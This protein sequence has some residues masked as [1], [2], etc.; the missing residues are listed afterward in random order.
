MK[1]QL[2]LW[3]VDFEYRFFDGKHNLRKSES[4]LIGTRS[5]EAEAAAQLVR[6]SFSVSGQE[7]VITAVAHQGEVFVFPTIA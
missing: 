4:A 6:N 5:E 2:S 7:L 3:K 1:T